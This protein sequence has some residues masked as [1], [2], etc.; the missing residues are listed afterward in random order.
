MI[1]KKRRKLI[2]ETAL[3]NQNIVDAQVAIA[4]A[5]ESAKQADDIDTMGE[6]RACGRALQGVWIIPSVEAVGR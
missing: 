2:S 6:L 5:L 1:T 4:R 3:G